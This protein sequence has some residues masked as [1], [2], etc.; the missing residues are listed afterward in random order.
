MTRARRHAG[1][2]LIELMISVA[3]LA[4]VISG[5]S[6]VLIKQSQAS[7]TQGMDRD[8]EESGRLAILEIGKAIRLAGYGIAPTAAFDFD[9]YACTIPGT[10]TTCNPATV[11]GLTSNFPR[12]RTDGPDELVLS[13]RDPTFT[14]RGVTSFTGGGPY[15]ATVTPALTASLKAGRIVEVLCDGLDQVAYFALT[16]DAAVG[17]TILTMQFTAN[18][19]GYYPNPLPIP[20]SATAVPPACMPAA[21]P[22]SLVYLTL[23]ERVRYFVANDTDGVP[24]L[25]RERGRGAPELLFRG[26]V[27]VQLTYTMT[28][29]PPSSPFAGVVVGPVTCGP[30]PWTYGL[31]SVSGTPP[32]TA[33]APDWVNDAYDSLNRYTG[34]PAD[35]HGV[36]I[37]VVARSAHKAPGSSGTGVPQIANRPAR[38]ADGYKRYVLSITEQPVNLASRGYPLLTVGKAGDFAN[39]GGG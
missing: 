39:V 26:I 4:F 8:L 38:A 27:D 17:A 37:T 20:P 11:G 29:P 16:A 24:G 2:T 35:I 32:E 31:C 30:D 12:D 7:A 13:Y 21:S 6:F 15:T 5:I 3:I 10:G 25:F 36:N 33:N 14:A 9:R 18:A 23:V 28:Q 34:H 1:F 19:D 22:S